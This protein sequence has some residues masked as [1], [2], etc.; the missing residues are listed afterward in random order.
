V[1]A[2]GRREGGRREGGKEEGGKEGRRKERSRE[3]GKEGR[4]EGTR[5]GKWRRC[6]RDCNAR[7][8]RER[9]RRRKGELEAVGVTGTN[10]ELEIL[11]PASDLSQ[12]I[13]TAGMEAS[14]T[15]NMKFAMNGGLIIGIEISI[16][17]RN[18]KFILIFFLQL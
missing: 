18:P 5:R 4:R 12:H 17:F 14:G 3:G 11:V 7:R 9:K 10:S 6:R 1:L 2:R 16:F 8:R 15:S 13:S